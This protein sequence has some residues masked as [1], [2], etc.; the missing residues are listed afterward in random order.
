MTAA[1][2]IGKLGAAGIKLWLDDE[3]QLRF[4]APKGALTAELKDQLITKLNDMETKDSDD[5]DYC[6]GKTKFPKSTSSKYPASRP[7]IYS[8]LR[9]DTSI[10]SNAQ[11]DSNDQID[12]NLSRH[13]IELGAINR[14]IDNYEKWSQLRIFLVSLNLAMCLGVWFIVARLP[15]W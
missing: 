5:R 15:L 11:I 10:D 7:I 2:L 14:V 13:L 9:I 4:K 1:Q 8:K 12:S 3:K 6:K